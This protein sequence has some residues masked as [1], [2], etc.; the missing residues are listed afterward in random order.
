MEALAY[1]LKLADRERLDI[2]YQPGD[3]QFLYNYAV[4]HSGQ[5]FWDDR[6]QGR[7]RHLLR[8]WLVNEDGRPLPHWFSDRHGSGDAAG[9][10]GD[11]LGT[12][13]RLNVPLV[14]S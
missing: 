14:A 7:T 4:L 2:D 5:A 13:T 8:N 10:P 9:R 6:H 12:D 1:L 3:M 11:M